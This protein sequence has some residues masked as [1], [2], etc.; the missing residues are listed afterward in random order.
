MDEGQ[1]DLARQRIFAAEG[2]S[3]KHES[4]SSPRRY[5]RSQDFSG[6]RQCGGS[7]IPEWQE[8]PESVPYFGRRTL[9][10]PQGISLDRSVLS[11]LRSSRRR[12]RSPHPEGKAGREDRGPTTSTTI[13]A[14]IFCAVSRR[15]WATKRGDA[16][17]KEVSHEITEPT[18]DSQVADCQAAGADVFVQLTYSKFAAQGI[19]KAAALAGSRCTSS[20][21]IAVRS[22]ERLPPPVSRMRRD[23]CRPG[24]KSSPP[25]QGSKTGRAVKAYLEFHEKIHAGGQCGR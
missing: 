18:I 3:N 14:R 5:L 7:E 24:G 17:V 1:S 4:W 13:W 11:D 25:I 23:W 20:I 16:I 8:G 10:Q 6:R 19:R 15:D 12:P 9:Q 21:R 2:R 22:V